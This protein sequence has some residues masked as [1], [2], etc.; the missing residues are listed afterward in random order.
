MV[1]VEGQHV[2]VDGLDEGE[3]LLTVDV[4]V[5]Q[6]VAAVVTQDALTAGTRQA[7]RRRRA[8]PLPNSVRGWAAMSMILVAMWLSVSVFGQDD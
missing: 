8:A 3:V 6:G 7:R 2:L 1:D 5:D 4:D